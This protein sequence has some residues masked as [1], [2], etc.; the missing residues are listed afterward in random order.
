ME[1]LDSAVRLEMHSTF[2]HSTFRQDFAFEHFPNFS[3]SLL[4]NAK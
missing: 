4:A 1:M 2:E 3:V